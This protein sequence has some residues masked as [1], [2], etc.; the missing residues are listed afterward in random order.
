M[1]RSYT[2]LPPSASMA[3]RGTALLFSRLFAWLN[4]KPALS[5]SLNFTKVYYNLEKYVIHLLNFMSYQFIL[6][7]S[8]GGVGCEI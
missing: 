4:M 7:Y 1:S 8:V 6:I 3:C 2:P 5:Y